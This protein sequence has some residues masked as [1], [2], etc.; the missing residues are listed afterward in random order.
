MEFFNRNLS[1]LLFPLIPLLLNSCATLQP[2]PHDARLPV[3]IL[4][5]RD[6]T[7]QYHTI[8]PSLEMLAMNA[9]KND[10]I[11]DKPHPSVTHVINRAEI[12]QNHFEP[13]D[14]THSQLTKY[15]LVG[16]VERVAYEPVENLQDLLTAYHLLGFLGIALASSSDQMGVYLQYRIQILNARHQP[17][18]SMVVVGVAI[19]DIA[20]TSRATLT[21]RA[22]LVAACHLVQQLTVIL[23]EHGI[24]VQKQLLWIKPH[25]ELWQ[26]CQDI[27][28]GVHITDTEAK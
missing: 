19:G 12:L 16:D 25:K 6:L 28:N 26:T 7:G 17:I 27:V 13:A 9:L 23:A 11:F 20:T 5:L 10:F 14:S 21:G 22:N 18:D 15:I 4:P 2:I 3:A 8:E 1:A 24:D